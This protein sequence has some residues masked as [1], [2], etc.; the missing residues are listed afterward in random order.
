MNE[1]NNVDLF[2]G[3]ISFEERSLVMPKKFV[4]SGG[5]RENIKVVLFADDS[6]EL[7]ENISQFENLG[8]MDVAKCNRL[9]S[10]SLWEWVW[11]IA[12]E[13]G[14]NILIDAT[15]LPREPLGMLLFALSVRR[16][17][18]QSVRVFYVAA[19]SCDRGGYATQNIKLSLDQQWLSRGVVRIRSIVGYPGNFSS[20]RVKHVVA[21]AG[22]EFER[23]L[24]TIVYYEPSRL[25]ISSENRDTSTVEGASAYSE[26]VANKLRT[27]I[28]LPNIEPVDFSANSI[29]DTYKKL[30]AMNI[31]YEGYNVAIVAMNTKLSF[32][33]AAL[34][35]LRKRNVRMVY[36]VPKEYNSLYCKGAGD[37]SEFD[38]TEMI[39]DARTIKV[40]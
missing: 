4:E 34:Y 11:G 21:F 6:V 15:C 1:M 2:V 28:P 27:E 23:L 39:K 19:P 38:I 3:A 5:K 8:I 18:L 26:I 36:S 20:E 14:G 37:I 22:H 35:A 31:D 16:D 33:G 30:M 40:R 10:R 7:S 17:Y 9:N 13:C 29:F 12:C 32:I 24:E 25:S